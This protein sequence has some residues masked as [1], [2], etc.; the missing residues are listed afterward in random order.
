MGHDRFALRA[1]WHAS[2]CHPHLGWPPSALPE[3]PP[4]SGSFELS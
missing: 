1:Q 4:S 3:D 2:L